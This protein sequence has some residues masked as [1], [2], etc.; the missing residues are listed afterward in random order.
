[1]FANFNQESLQGSD[2]HSRSASAKDIARDRA[3]DQSLT[4]GVAPL[5]L[6]ISDAGVSAEGGGDH[7]L[8]IEAHT[9]VPP[10]LSSTSLYGNQVRSSPRLCIV[11]LSRRQM[12]NR[13]N[14]IAPTIHAFAVKCITALANVAPSLNTLY[15]ILEGAGGDVRT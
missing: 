7:D 6:V 3:L 13:F 10:K 12:S 4:W 14:P 5:V 8:A 15:L 11:S 2:L 9:V 1:M